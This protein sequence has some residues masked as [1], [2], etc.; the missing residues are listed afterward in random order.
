ML[1]AL[2]MAVEVAGTVLG[3]VFKHTVSS[4]ISAG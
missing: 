4:R 1:V 3:I 2:V